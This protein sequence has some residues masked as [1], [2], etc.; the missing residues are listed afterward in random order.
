MISL[1]NFAIIRP[2]LLVGAPGVPMMHRYLAKAR[3]SGV[4]ESTIR[5]WVTQAR[6]S[7]PAG[8]VRTGK[9]RRNAQDRVDHRWLESARTILDSYTNASR[10]VRGNV[11][12]EGWTAA[13][14]GRSGPPPRCRRVTACQAVD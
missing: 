9:L 5:L 14:S 3:E 1:G 10:P 8:L 6:K 11:E 4:G 13:V 12:L 2:L 7:G